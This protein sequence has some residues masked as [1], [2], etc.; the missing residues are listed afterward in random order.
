MPYR[1]R[2]R[3]R[4]AWVTTQC[5]PVSARMHE[6]I[7]PCARADAPAAGAGAAVLLLVRRL[8]VSWR[9]RRSRP[10]RRRP[11]HAPA[12]HRCSLLAAGGCFD[13]AIAQMCSR[14]Q[15]CNN[16]QECR[17]VLLCL[18]ASNCSD[19]YMRDHQDI[20]FQAQASRDTS[21]VLLTVCMSRRLHC[22]QPSRWRSSCG[23]SAAGRP[24]VA[25]AA[26]AVRLSFY[27]G[28]ASSA[29]SPRQLPRQLPDETANTSWWRLPY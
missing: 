13:A 8:R 5:C 3:C 22:C 14:K 18:A 19:K 1:W 9:R 15:H 4:D 16:D 2:R 24:A 28:G 12:P 26:A 6:T 11:W 7:H 23:R 17:G 21:D 27:L 25:P 20:V 10:S 29:G